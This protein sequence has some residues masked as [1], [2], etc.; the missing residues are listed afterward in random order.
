[1]DS[2]RDTII[3]KLPDIIEQ[4]VLANEK[5]LDPQESE[6]IVAHLVQFL[7]DTGRIVYGGYAIHK[8][9][10]LKGKKIYADD[11]F[12]D[13]DLYSPDA[14]GDSV[15]L[16]DSMFA[17]GY[18][19]V[20]VMPAIHPDTYRIQVN[21]R[22]IADVTNVP[23]TMYSLIPT[24]SINGIRYASPNFLKIDLLRGLLEPPENTYRW[25][26]DVK[27]F[28]ELERYYPTVEPV[29]TGIKEIVNGIIKTTDI[30]MY[31]LF[32][33]FRQ[34]KAILSGMSAYNYYNAVT[35]NNDSGTLTDVVAFVMK[36][37]DIIRQ[38]RELNVLV[39][40]EESNILEL[41]PKHYVITWNDIKITL[42]LHEDECISTIPA[43]FIV[44]KKKIDIDVP[45]FHHLLKYFYVLAFYKDAGYLRICRELLTLQSKYFKEHKLMGA[46][47]GKPFAI[48][49]I[50]CYGT[51]RNVMYHSN[52][53]R[54]NSQKRPE[55]RRRLYEPEHVKRQAT[56]IH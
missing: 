34:S 26:K 31:K 32:D 18:K 19:Y 39:E 28:T 9:L 43:K 35:K 44:G 25:A 6:K 33:I 56:K 4:G 29:P 1:M 22:F 16:A 40:R 11:K 46:E 20:R 12:P 54:Y 10:E 14:W 30:S 45:V 48:F 47:Q 41:L 21:F 27:R 5:E 36:P 2:I 3:K 50:Q 51:S 8:L 23:E 13:Y 52:V 17:R 24:Q 15:K 38:L 53:L 55:L 49:Q 42:Y 7:K 37:L